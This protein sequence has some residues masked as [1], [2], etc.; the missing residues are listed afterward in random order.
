M[1]EKIV[2]AIDNDPERSAKVV[3]AARELAQKFQSEVVVAHVREV[4]RPTTEEEAVFIS[5]VLAAWLI[6]YWK[7]QV[8]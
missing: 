7:T 4:E 2:A 3:D 8:D 6:G 1:F 5:V